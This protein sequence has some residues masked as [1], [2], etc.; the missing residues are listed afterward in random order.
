MKKKA[1]IS[2]GNNKPNVVVADNVNDLP[3]IN[4]GIQFQYKS[5][6]WSKLKDEIYY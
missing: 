5:A 6:D 1:Q 4:W 3:D 2:R